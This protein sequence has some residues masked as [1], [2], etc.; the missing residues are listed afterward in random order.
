MAETTEAI[1]LEVLR[2]ILTDL[3]ETRK[4]VTAFRAEMQVFRTEAGRR[5][6]GLDQMVADSR[7]DM[8]GLLATGTAL[9]GHMHQRIGDLECRLAPQNVARP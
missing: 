9:A 4:E 3:G 6:D 8:A 1:V 7:R 5:L 2:R